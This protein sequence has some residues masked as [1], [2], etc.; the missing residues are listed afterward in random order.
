[1]TSN[2][3][4]LHSPLRLLCREGLSAVTAYIL[5]LVH[6]SVVLRQ[7]SG[8]VLQRVYPIVEAVCI[9]I[10]HMY[11]TLPI[12]MSAAVQCKAGHVSSHFDLRSVLIHLRDSNR[13]CSTFRLLQ[14]I[15]QTD[16]GYS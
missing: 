1:M 16:E 5:F 13:L 15:S 3:Q 6:L 9:R 11:I 4:H 14:Y 12:Y 10:L 8:W 7:Q 2:H